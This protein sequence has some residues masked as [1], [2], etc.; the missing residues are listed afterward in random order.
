MNG[1]V[2]GLSAALLGYFDFIFSVDDAYFLTP[3]SA[4]SLVCE[5]GS[6]QSLVQRMGLAKANECVLLTMLSPNHCTD[7]PDFQT[8][9]GR[10][11]SVGK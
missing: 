8:D 9:A 2:I 1:P 11:C 4:I 6:S 3:F 10:C 7:L 5:G